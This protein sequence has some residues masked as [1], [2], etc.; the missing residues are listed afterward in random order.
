MDYK[1]FTYPK[2]EKLKSRTLIKRVFEEGKVI[3]AYPILIKYVEIDKEKHLV[4]V[5]VSKR[6]FKKAV[7]RIRLKRQLREAYRLNKSSLIQKPSKYAIM[8]GFIGKKKMDYKHIQTKVNQ[9]LEE[10][11]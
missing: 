10:M 9:L 4:S 6:I 1:E 2:K 7:D 3:K 11:N 8:I 5:N